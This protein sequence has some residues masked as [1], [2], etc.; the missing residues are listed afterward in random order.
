VLFIAFVVWRYT[1]V[2]RGARQR[3]EIILSRLDALGTK[4]GNGEEVSVEDVA[5]AARAP[6]NRPL[7]YEVLKHY[8]QTNLFPSEYLDP[9]EQGVA[10][11]SYWLMHPNE[12]GAAPA[13]VEHV[14]DFDREVN[15]RK[16]MFSVYR[17]KEASEAP[18]SLM[19]VVGPFYKAG[20]INFGATAFS[21]FDAESEDFDPNEFVDWYISILR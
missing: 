7:L 20:A 6:E 9:R 5:E 15:N 16:A 8:E 18:Q 13:E 1:S 3:D 11:L 19:G 4:L 14:G 2:R 12:S 21:R 17:F 10:L